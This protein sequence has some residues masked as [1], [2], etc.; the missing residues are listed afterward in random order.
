MDT[1]ITATDSEKEKAEK[2]LARIWGTDRTF[3]KDR[4]LLA[5]A[6]AESRVLGLD[7][8]ITLT[9]P[10]MSG[11]VSRARKL[12]QQRILYRSRQASEAILRA[13]ADE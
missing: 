5:Q 7:A 11:E 1:K 9:Y 12:S 2:L 6:L 13:K 3:E 8:P 4:N 10:G